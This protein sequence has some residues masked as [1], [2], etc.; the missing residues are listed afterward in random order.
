MKTIE[1]TNTEKR[2]YS[3]PDVEKIQLDNEISLA[4]ESLSP[5]AGPFEIVKNGDNRQNPFDGTLNA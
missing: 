2:A 4:L 1:T 5:P 3:S